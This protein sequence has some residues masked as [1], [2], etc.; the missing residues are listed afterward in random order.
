MYYSPKLLNIELESPVFDEMR[1]MELTNLVF[2]SSKNCEEVV[3][4]HSIF[5]TS[6]F[7]SS[8]SKLPVD[9]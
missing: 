7:I 2:R 6:D 3:F 4:H 5:R 1:L 9:I 8:T